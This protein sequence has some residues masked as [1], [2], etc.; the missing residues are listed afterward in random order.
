MR[1]QLSSTVLCSTPPPPL[2]PL[3]EAAAPVQ[4]QTVGRSRCP[5][6]IRNCDIVASASQAFAFATPSRGGASTETSYALGPSKPQVISAILEARGVCARQH[7]VAAARAV[8]KLTPYCRHTQAFFPRGGGR[9]SSLSLRSPPASPLI[10]RIQ[11]HAPPMEERPDAKFFFA[12]KDV[13][14]RHLEL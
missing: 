2:L 7:H 13:S 11:V 1:A 14:Q 3:M 4:L 12:R 10:P 9:A 6:H 8:A 5:F